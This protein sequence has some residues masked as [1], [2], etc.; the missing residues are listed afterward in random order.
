MNPNLQLNVSHMHIKVWVALLYN[1]LENSMDELMEWEVYVSDLFS[2][3]KWSRNYLSVK[4]LRV[5][6]L[7]GFKDPVQDGIPP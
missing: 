2:F 4:L 7:N 1:Q 6:L 5:K 3:I